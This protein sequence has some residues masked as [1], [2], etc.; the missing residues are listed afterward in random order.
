ML[1]T[2]VITWPT[3]MIYLRSLGDPCLTSNLSQVIQTLMGAQQ[4]LAAEAPWDFGPPSS[5]N[6]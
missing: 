6:E 2:A 4:A 3:A 1:F 5:M